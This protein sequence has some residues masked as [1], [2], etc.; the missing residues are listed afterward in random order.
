[1]QEKIICP[2]CGCIVTGEIGIY[3]RLQFN[4]YYGYCKKCDYSIT[5]SEWE[6]VE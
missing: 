5:E 1:M 3:E 6:K 4:D 2:K